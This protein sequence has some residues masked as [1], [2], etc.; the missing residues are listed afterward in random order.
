M[1]KALIIDDERRALNVLKLLIERHLP[2][3]QEVQTALGSAKG[4]AQIYAERP[5]LVFLDVEMPGMTGFELLE[6]VK[7][8][9]I[10]VIFTTAYDQ[11]AIRAIRFSAIDYLLKPIDLQE[12]KS[13]VHKF[14]QRPHASEDLNP[15]LANL[16]SNLKS[17]Q[18]QKP[19]LAIS[20][21]GGLVFFDIEEIVRCQADN[22]YSI[23]HLLNGKKFVSAKS[24]KEY[25]ELLSEYHFL[26]VHQSHLVNP[27]YIKAY[28]QKGLMELKDGSHV[29]VSRRK[30][31]WVQQKLRSMYL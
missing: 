9:A 20:T 16:I 5:D 31:Q 23:F 2:E 29:Q 19:R 8:L 17:T 3:I 22:N 12:L 10:N 28:T 15:L 7:D 18:A 30:H 13:A 6:V 26:R 14:L 21:L 4:L 11:Y 24:L 1:I 27:V 25:D